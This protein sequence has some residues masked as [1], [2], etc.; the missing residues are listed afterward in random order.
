MRTK[1]EITELSLG[2]WDYLTTRVPVNG[3]TFLPGM[4]RACVEFSLTPDFNSL[5]IEM[6]LVEL[7]GLM[8]VLAGM[9]LKRLAEVALGETT[10]EIPIVGPPC[11]HGAPVTEETPS[12]FAGAKPIRT[13]ADGCQSYGPYQSEG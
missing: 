7:A 6:D 1:I 10:G 2:Q 3:R 4:P 13:Y 5:H 12:A 9:D 11:E 8:V